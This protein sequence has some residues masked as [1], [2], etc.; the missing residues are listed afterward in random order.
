MYRLPCAER[1]DND[2]AIW[3]QLN[4][5][6]HGSVTMGMDSRGTLDTLPFDPIF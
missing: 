6:L 4:K 3:A 1:G 2:I 5:Q